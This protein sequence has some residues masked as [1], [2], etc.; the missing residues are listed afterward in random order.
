MKRIK[1]FGSHLSRRQRRVY[2]SVIA[3]Y[4]VA[5]LATTWPVYAVFSRARPIVLGMPFSLFYI[6]C[7]VVASFLTLYALFRWEERQD[8][9]EEDT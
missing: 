7:F 9:E 5:I 8:G 2:G 3:F 1:I 4:V 6:A